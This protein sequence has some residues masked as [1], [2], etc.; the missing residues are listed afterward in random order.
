MTVEL[1]VAGTKTSVPVEG[2]VEALVMFADRELEKLTVVTADEEAGAFGSEP[3]PV[4]TGAG[5]SVVFVVEAGSEFCLF[6]KLP[7]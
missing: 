7:S 1:I 3:K 5:V 4:A 2:N 6:G